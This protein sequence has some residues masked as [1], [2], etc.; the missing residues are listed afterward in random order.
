Q[1]QTMVVSPGEEPITPRVHSENGA[2]GGVQQRL[3]MSKSIVRELSALRSPQSMSRRMLATL[4]ATM[5]AQSQYKAQPYDGHVTLFRV[6]QQTVPD[7]DAQTL[8]WKQLVGRGVTVHHLPG[9]HLN[10]MR[11]PQVQ[12]LAEQLQPYLE[13]VAAERIHQA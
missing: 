11:S 3:Q 10:M 13:S 4:Q 9:H 8:G 12:M 7:D 5:Q 6:A 2:T 1:A